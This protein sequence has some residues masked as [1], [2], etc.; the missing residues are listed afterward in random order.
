MKKNK[1]FSISII[2]TLAICA[3]AMMSIADSE[4]SI[5]ESSPPAQQETEIDRALLK[6]MFRPKE[7]VDKSQETIFPGEIDFKDLINPSGGLTS[8][9][10]S[11]VYEQKH[12]KIIEFTTIPQIDMPI[13]KE[14]A[15]KGVLEHA[16]LKI[17]TLYEAIMDTSNLHFFHGDITLEILL[18]KEGRVKT[19]KI[20][21]SSVRV[22]DVNNSLIDFVEQLDFEPVWYDK[23]INGM[24]VKFSF[25]P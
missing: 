20:Q 16:R 8:L 12:V 10:P 1:L 7:D 14:A 17:A 4:D 19:C 6:G 24:I 18:N 3:T 22:P 15:F 13:Q 11:S 25:R 2:V 21:G 23:R 9:R 5:S